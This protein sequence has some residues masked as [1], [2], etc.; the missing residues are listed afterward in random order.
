M[1]LLSALRSRWLVLAMLL[2]VAVPATYAFSG[3]I[4]VGCAGGSNAPPGEF[5]QFG[6]ASAGCHGTAHTFPAL[7]ATNVRVSV[8][9]AEGAPL[10]GPYEAH[11][12][13]T[14]TISLD[15]QNAP[16]AANHAGF[17]LR[18]AA[19]TLSAVEGQSQ[20]SADGKQATHVGPGLIS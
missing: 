3:G 5:A 7:N 9:D 1:A 18:A 4:C 6:C 14:I 11:G 16:E 8:V 15:E 13:Y 20:V 10:N 2:V 12:V 17:N 19:G